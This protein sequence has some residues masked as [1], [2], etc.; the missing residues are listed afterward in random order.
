MPAKPRIVLSTKR[1]RKQDARREQ[2][3]RELLEHIRRNER[4]RDD[5]RVWVEQYQRDMERLRRN[6]Y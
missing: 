2:E 6:I 5:A 4:R 1:A 3:R